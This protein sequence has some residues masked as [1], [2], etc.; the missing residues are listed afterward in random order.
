MV[1]RQ[2]WVLLAVFAALIGLAFF[3]TRFQ[4]DR[5]KSSPTTTPTP[6]QYIFTMD[7]ATVASLKI[8]DNVS[9][10]TVMVARDVTGQWMLVDPQ[11][12][13][14][15][16]ASVE[17]AVTQLASLKV[18]SSLPT[19]DNLA[20]Y[21]LDQPAYTIV[22]NVN[23]GGQ[24]LAQVGSATATSSG[25]YMLVPGGVPQIVAKYGLDA[26]LKLLLNPPIATPTI[27]PTV[28]GATEPTVMT[29]AT[30]AIPSVTST[31]LPA[32]TDTPAPAST[33]TLAPVTTT[34]EPQTTSSPQAA[35]PTPLAATPTETAKP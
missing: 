21:G 24:L 9:G 11:A 19:S 34:P 29:T 28:P 4:N 1:K 8:T 32:S 27:A 7:S 18:T 5:K 23:D 30:L 2:T 13:Y 17:S 33:A 25:Y 20:E 3:W 22:V 26:V 6:A 35:S 15:D 16:V 14:T 31:P 12:E 10:K